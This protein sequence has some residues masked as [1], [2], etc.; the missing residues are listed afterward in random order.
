MT[1]E[2]EKSEA[3]EATE[4]KQTHDANVKKYKTS[5]IALAATLILFEQELMYVEPINKK[6]GTRSEIF[7]FVFKDTPKREQLVIKYSSNN[8]DIRVI[9]NAFRATMRYLKELT[10]NYN[11]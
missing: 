8:D 6:P 2:K 7:H 5:D 11:K 10:K 1:D 3:Q 4:P 9:P